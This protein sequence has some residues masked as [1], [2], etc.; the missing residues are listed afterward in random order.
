MYKICTYIYIFIYYTKYVFETPS[1]FPLVKALKSGFL[2]D[3][4]GLFLSFSDKTYL[5]PPPTPQSPTTKYHFVSHGQMCVSY[6]SR[7]LRTISSQIA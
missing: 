5:P 4:T 6:N 1:I 7:T 3:T 2:C